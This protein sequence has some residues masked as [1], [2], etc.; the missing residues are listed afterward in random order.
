[1][2]KTKGPL[3][4]LGARGSIAKSQVYARWKG[5]DYARVHVDPANPRTVEQTSTRDVFSSLNTQWKYSP[6]LAQAPFASAAQG[7]PVT[8]RNLFIQA[9]LSP[10][11][12]ETDMELFVG[13]PGSR[14]GIPP[15][16]LS[17]AAPGAGALNASLTT[18]DAPTDW[19]LS[20]VVGVAFVDRDPHVQPVT[21]PVAA[22][23]MTPTAGGVSVIPFTGLTPGTYIVSAWPVWTKPDGFLAYGPSMT[24]SIVVT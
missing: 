9:N 15:T 16:L 22:E 20:Q 6:A 10:M 1:M 13:S 5:V 7:K 14:G 11:R 24:D 2:A 8:D 3:L 21:F 4:S 12:S 17:L 18:T 19:T 23:D